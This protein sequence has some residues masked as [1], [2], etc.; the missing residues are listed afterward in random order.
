MQILQGN[1][2]NISLWTRM[3]QIRYVL[4]LFSFLNHLLGING[5][6]STYLKI[7]P[8]ATCDHREMPEY[9]Y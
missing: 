3:V 7:E 9:Y 8:F 4:V 1:T 6:K 2:L 5:H